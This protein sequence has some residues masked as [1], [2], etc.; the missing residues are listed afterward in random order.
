MKSPVH[1]QVILSVFL[2]AE[3]R[4]KPHKSLFEKTPCH[5]A[6]LSAATGHVSTESKLYT[7][8]AGKK[9][10]RLARLWRGIVFDSPPAVPLRETLICCKKDTTREGLPLLRPDKT[11]LTIHDRGPYK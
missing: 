2:G 1:C 5:T 9:G 4:G 3:N 7:T 8:I 11:G 6:A 10:T